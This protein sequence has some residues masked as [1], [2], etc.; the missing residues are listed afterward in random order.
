MPLVFLTMVAECATASR[1]PSSGGVVQGR[2]VLL[3]GCVDG[4]H[5]APGNGLHHSVVPPQRCGVQGCGA[6]VGGVAGVG[7][8]LEELIDHGGLTVLC[9][10][11]QRGASEL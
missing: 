8:Q 11:V 3:V 7:P 1:K 4:G 5:W 6:V 10:D 9:R 2:A